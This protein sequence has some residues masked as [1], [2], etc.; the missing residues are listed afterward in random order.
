M[1]RS[2]LPTSKIDLFSD[3]VLEDP[4]PFYAELREQG[5]VVWI[6][7]RQVWAITR[8]EGIRSALDN[9][10]TF[11]SRSVAFNDTMNQFIVGSALASDPPAHTQL[12]SVLSSSLSPRALRGLKADIDAKAQ[13]LVDSL[14]ERGSFDAMDDLA[15]AFPLS[16]VID[17]IGVQ[18]DDR[19]KVLGWG[20]ASFNLFGPLNERAERD[21]GQSMELFE[22]V[23]SRTSSDL[24]DG[25]FGRATFEAAERGDIARE[26]CA[27]ILM[28]YVGAGLD[29]T[30]AALGNAVALFAAHDDQWDLVRERPDLLPAAFNEV[31][32]YEP[33]LQVFGR[34]VVREHEIEGTVLAS[35]D[36][37]AILFGSGNRDESHFPDAD[38]F[39]ITRDASDHLSFGYGV[40]SCAGQGLA[41]LEAN[42]VLTALAKRVRRFH[43]GEPQRVLG[44]VTR[45]LDKLPVL[46]LELA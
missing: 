29:T 2:T 46:D 12:R 39:D 27:A 38:R 5:P 33:P 1:S 4:Y 40:H 14:L 16:V 35:G 44:N 32:R 6:E 24:A 17:L 11:S 36:M 20:E 10:E 45:G 9:W 8:Y 21:L 41:R 43:V 25:S 7:P 26:S 23:N 3:E 34:R 13:T 28:S 42:A 22:Y 30:I 18:G 19:A 37:A 31:L 15:R